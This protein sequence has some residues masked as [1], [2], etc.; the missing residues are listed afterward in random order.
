MGCFF[1]WVRIEEGERRAYAELAEHFDFFSVIVKAKINA[2]TAQLGQKVQFS[3]LRNLEIQPRLLFS[4]SSSESSNS[5]ITKALNIC[6]PTMIASKKNFQK[7][8][9]RKQ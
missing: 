4:S 3:K 1:E 2:L 6:L 9:N 7:Q 8:R 5:A